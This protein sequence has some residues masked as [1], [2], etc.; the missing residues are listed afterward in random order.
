VAA[1]RALVPAL[2]RVA[3]SDGTVVLA[4]PSRD[5]PGARVG[6]S[7]YELTDLLEPL[8]PSVKMVGQAPFAGATLVEYGVADPEPVLDGTL[9]PKGER[10]EWYVAVAGRKRE[11][12]RG[13]GVV[14]VPLAEVVAL[15]AERRVAPPEPARAAPPPPMVSPPPGRFAQPPPSARR[16]P[17]PRDP[18]LDEIKERLAAAEK[19]KSELQDFVLALKQQMSERDAYVAELDGERRDLG[20]L[21]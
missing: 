2:R 6:V 4:V 9:V 10:V 18:G 15:P 16:T 7:Y 5:R 21:R 17:A 3:K 19:G 14:Q 20:R 12:S 13:Y 1:L 8:F 11:G